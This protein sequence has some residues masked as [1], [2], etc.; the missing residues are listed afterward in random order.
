MFESDSDSP[1]MGEGKRR[2]EFL[3]QEYLFRYFIFKSSHA[4]RKQ[5]FISDCINMEQTLDEI[6]NNIGGT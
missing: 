2:E 5:I 6:L 1:I 3:F 4:I